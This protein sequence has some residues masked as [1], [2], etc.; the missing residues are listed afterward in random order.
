MNKVRKEKRSGGASPG[1]KHHHDMLKIQSEHR[2][3]WRSGRKYRIVKVR[4]RDMPG[5]L[6]TLEA[7]MSWPQLLWMR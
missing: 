1:K 5:S 7:S 3:I 2:I 4:L 6:G